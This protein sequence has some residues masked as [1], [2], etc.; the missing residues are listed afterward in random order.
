M[1]ETGRTYTILP[2]TWMVADRGNWRQ[3]VLTSTF[4]R[5]GGLLVEKIEEVRYASRALSVQEQEALITAFKNF[6][7]IHTVLHTGSE[8]EE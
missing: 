1:I 2:L 8:K 7:E 3:D 5:A 6:L 4:A